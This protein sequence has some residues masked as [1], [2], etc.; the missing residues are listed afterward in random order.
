MTI[1]SFDDLLNT[2]RTQA[3][4]QTL[5]MVFVD[6]ELPDD[7]SAAERERFEAGL[8]GNLTPRMCLDRVAT[9]VQDWASLQQ[10]AD[11][12]S[13]Q[14]RMVLVAALGGTPHK[15]ASNDA[16]DQALDRMV[17]AVHQGQIQD[18][19]PLDRQGQA[20]RFT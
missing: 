14:W 4:V 15:R 17:M 20:V 7:A 8:G 6:V 3:N 19:F 2:S 13:D 10:E 16:I 18:Y 9:D 5:L 12:Q 1:T 11:Q